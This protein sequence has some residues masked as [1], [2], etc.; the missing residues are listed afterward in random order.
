MKTPPHAFP[1]KGEFYKSPGM[2]LRDWFAGQ[3]FP[4]AFKRAE[5]NLMEGGLY[6]LAAKYAYG[7]ADAMVAER[8]KDA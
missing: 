6:Q 3:V 8:N 7:M 4:V 2:E 1:Y 5:S